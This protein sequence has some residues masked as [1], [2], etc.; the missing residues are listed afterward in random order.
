MGR[1]YPPAIKALE[2]RRDAAEVELLSAPT[3]KD[4]VKSGL[5]DNGAKRNPLLAGAHGENV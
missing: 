3:F 1:A 2:K 4:R 5:E